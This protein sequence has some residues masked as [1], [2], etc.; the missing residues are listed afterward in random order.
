MADTC[1]GCGAK[2]T[3]QGIFSNANQ[4]LS[5]E[6]LT[7]VNFVNGTDHL[8]LCDACGGT[9]RDA[10]RAR[11]GDERDKL[12]ADVNAR[13]SYFPSLTVNVLPGS[14]TYQALGLVTANVTVGTGIFNEVSQ[15]VSDLFG[16]VNENS[17]MAFK[18][19]RGEGA[20]K[21]ILVRKALEMGANCIIG[22]DIDY[23]VTTNNAATVNMQGTAILVPELGAILGG[24]ALEMTTWILW[25]WARMQL[26]NRWLHGDV[27]PGDKLST[28]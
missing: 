11:L 25:A 24:R 20:A 23:G 14:N 22:T 9:L 2:F 3:Q 6:D 27:Q 26:L 4:R 21:A 17:G 10:A 16:A 12:K 15:S 5:T 7:I 8:E 1:A 28:D 19:N 13:L 18:V